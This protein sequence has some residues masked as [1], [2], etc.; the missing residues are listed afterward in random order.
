[1][2]KVAQVFPFFIYTLHN[3]TYYFSGEIV[4]LVFVLCEK[5]K[6]F[7]FIQVLLLVTLWIMLYFRFDMQEL[8]IRYE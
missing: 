2:C 6:N 3:T 4:L 8:Y 7:L 1:M 5:K